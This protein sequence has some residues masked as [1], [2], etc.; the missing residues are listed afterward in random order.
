MVFEMVGR[1]SGKKRSSPVDIYTGF[2]DRE[3]PL[4]ALE[5]A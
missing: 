5:P 4:A 3:I 2:T 1:R